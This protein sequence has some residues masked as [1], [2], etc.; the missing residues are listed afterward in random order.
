M[1]GDEGRDKTLRKIDACLL[2]DVLV[3][4]L[5]HILVQRISPGLGHPRSS[6]LPGIPLGSIQVEKVERV[7]IED[8]RHRSKFQVDSLQASFPSKGFRVL[9][10]GSHKGGRGHFLVGKGGRVHKPARTDLGDP[11]VEVMAVGKGFG[12]LGREGF[13]KL[14]HMV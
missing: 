11:D 3:E 13:Q 4:R 8:K 2:K 1:D 7:D 14:G 9:G 5:K 6:L 12:P 10:N